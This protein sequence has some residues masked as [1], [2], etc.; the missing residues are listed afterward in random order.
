MKTKLILT[1]A[2]LAVL[3][4]TTYLYYSARTDNK[5]ESEV[6]QT[7]Q[8]IDYSPATDEDQE[9]ADR[10]KQELIENSDSESNTDEKTNQTTNEPSEAKDDINVVLTFIE[11]R[12]NKIVAS[13]FAQT[14]KNGQ[15]ILEISNASQT[16]QYT[17]DP[18]FNVNK[19]D[20]RFDFEQPQISNGIYSAEITYKTN[21]SESRSNSLEFEVQ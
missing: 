6:T 3:L 1:S 17:A 7:D 9:Q 19:Y 11:D 16:S 20:C 21:T 18:I 8:T 15:C 13:A 12:G 2:I 4:T 10:L 5:N 14:T